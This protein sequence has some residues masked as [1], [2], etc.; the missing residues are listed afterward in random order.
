[1][2]AHFI[3]ENTPQHRK[4]KSFC[5]GVLCTILKFKEVKIE[6]VK[7]YFAFFAMRKP[8]SK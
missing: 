3:N 8:T 6:N 4:E 7:G 1:M 2:F 5:H